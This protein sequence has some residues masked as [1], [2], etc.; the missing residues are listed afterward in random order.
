MTFNAL[1]VLDHMFVRDG[2]E[3]V[4]LYMKGTQCIFLGHIL[5]NTTTKIKQPPPLFFKGAMS[6]VSQVAFSI[7]I[8]L[9][10]H[11][12]TCLYIKHFILTHH[13]SSPTAY[14]SSAVGSTAPLQSH[15]T[16]QATC[17]DTAP[18]TGLSM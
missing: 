12:P 7:C 15:E 4:S 10:L 17:F 9:Y 11:F 13:I 16:I 18:P 5:K 2:F 6:T 3:F 8:C 1:E 14:D